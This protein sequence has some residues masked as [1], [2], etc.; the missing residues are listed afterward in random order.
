M[1]ESQYTD[2]RESS[3]AMQSIRNGVAFVLASSVLISD[4]QPVITLY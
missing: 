1:T 3:W 4:S 2:T